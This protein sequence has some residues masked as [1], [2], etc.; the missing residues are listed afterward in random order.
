[1]RQKSSQQKAVS[2]LDAKLKDQNKPTATKETGTRRKSTRNRKES[3]IS[4]FAMTPHESG[5]PQTQASEAESIP[6]IPTTFGSAS[7]TA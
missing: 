1:M 3:Q 5:P 2:D 7:F 6:K 4:F